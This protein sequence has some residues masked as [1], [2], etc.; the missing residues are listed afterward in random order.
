MTK[1][2][3]RL[4]V[5]TVCVLLTCVLVGAI[6]FHVEKNDRYFE[7]EALT[8][9]QSLCAKGFP[10]D[11]AAALTE[12]HLLHPTWEFVPLMISKDSPLY[13]WNYVITQETKEIDNNLIS[14]DI[15]YLAYRHP[16]HSGKFDAGHYPASVE[17]VKYFMD[18]RNFL[19][20][21]DIFQ[22]FDL[23]VASDVSVEAVEAVLK[24]TFMEHAVLENGMT[25]AEYF[26]KVGRELSV[27]P[28]YLAVKA[29]Q[30]QGRNGS[31]PIIGGQCGTLLDTYYRNQTQY[32]SENAILTPTY[33]YTSLEL[34]E[35]NG[36]YN[37][38]NI[39]A[40]GNGLF[41]I[42]YNAMTRAQNGTP[43][44]QETW[45]SAS[46]NTVWKSIYGGAY[47]IKASYID[48]YQNTIYLQ[49]FNVDSRS[50]RNF[51]GQY[52]QNVGAALTEGR[53]LYTSFASMGALDS[54]C[55]FLIPVY[56][57]MPSDFAADPAHGTC[58]YLAKATDKYTYNATLNAPAQKKDKD[59]ALYLTQQTVCGGALSLAGEFSHSYGIS[60]LEYQWDGTGEWIPCSTD[61]ALNLSLSVDFSENTSH[62]LIIRGRA[63]YNP[64]DS[65]KKSNCYFLC[66][67]IYVEVISPPQNQIAS[68][69]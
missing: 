1:R 11:Y 26:L 61:G 66:A 17:A 57:G 52:M 51:W 7:G 34:L 3:V 48:R 15:S 23:S 63:A 24:D 21:T 68:D 37:V 14:S 41:S 20:E 8:Y 31:S 2:R 49:K 5:R 4:V 29:R 38:F 54:D 39:G 19:N 62:I 27:S 56:S 9:Y 50:D 28:I 6:V 59:Q 60:Q 25:Y 65:T 47:S 58:S 46:W 40:S 32:S 36:L 69:Q 45:G 16:L 43:S 55:T 67:V 42:Y 10:E 30:E 53:T 44:M 35:L 22:F 64:D 18:P 33:G 13:T 12:L